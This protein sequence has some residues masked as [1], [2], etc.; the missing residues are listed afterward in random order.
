M[1]PKVMLYMRTHSGKSPP[2]RP[3]NVMWQPSKDGAVKVIHWLHKRLE[4]G[5]RFGIAEKVL[6]ML[7]DVCDS[8]AQ[9]RYLWPVVMH[10]T[11]GTTNEQTLMGR[12]VRGLQG[13]AARTGIDAGI[14]GGPQGQQ[15][16][17]DFVC[18]D[19]R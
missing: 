18:V 3:Q 13:A 1:R 2:L 9:V 7:S 16:V 11:K 12:E 19:R 8:G 4:I 6:R 15:R 10:L 5:K 17:A 14:S